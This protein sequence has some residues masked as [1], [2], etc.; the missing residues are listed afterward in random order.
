MSDRSQNPDEL[1]GA[2]A[3]DGKKTAEDHLYSAARKFTLAE[4]D[5]Q[6][7]KR[8]FDEARAA[9]T[10][11]VCRACGKVKGEHEGWDA[12]C[13]INSIEVARGRLIYDK[14]TGRATEVRD[15]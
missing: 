3:A 15:A 5:A 14:Q 2:S 10:A 9:S 1:S 7:A 8:K 11:V 12:S 13:E 6:I 4:Q